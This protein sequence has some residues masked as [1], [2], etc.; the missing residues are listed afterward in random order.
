[1]LSE[2]L[3]EAGLDRKKLRQ[4][5]KQALEGLMLMCQWQLE[6]IREHEAREAAQPPAPRGRRARRVPMA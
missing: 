6:R 2:A 3:Q 1:M 4:V 5:R